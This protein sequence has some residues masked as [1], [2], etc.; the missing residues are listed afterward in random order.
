MVLEVVLKKHFDH[1][2]EIY[3]C[4]FIILNILII[5]SKSIN[6]GYCIPFNF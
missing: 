2:N 4:T 5:L 3:V 1:F 6:V